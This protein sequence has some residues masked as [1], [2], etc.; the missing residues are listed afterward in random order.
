MVKYV[1]NADAIITVVS[2]DGKE[3]SVTERAFNVVYS[4]QGYTRVGKANERDALKKK[5]NDELKNI[6]NEKGIDYPSSANKEE[7]VDLIL[8][9]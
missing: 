6:L 1:K 8:G 5:T 4:G 2:P 3:V 7:L 9:E